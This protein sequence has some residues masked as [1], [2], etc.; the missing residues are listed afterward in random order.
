[1][2]GRRLA[3]SEDCCREQCEFVWAGRLS[4]PAPTNN[5]VQTIRQTSPENHVAPKC[6]WVSTGTISANAAP[7]ADPLISAALSSKM[8]ISETIN[9]ATPPAA[10]RR[11]RSRVSGAASRDI[12]AATQAP[13]AHAKDTLAIAAATID[14]NII[15]CSITSR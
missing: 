13:T 2:S 6:D 12:R 1:M 8:T 9:M 4:L 7:G 3:E 14:A 15:A 10:N 11:S 5:T